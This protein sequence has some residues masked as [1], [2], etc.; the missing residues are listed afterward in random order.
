MSDSTGTQQTTGAAPR[1]D[2]YEF[3][4]DGWDDIEL[5]V[6]IL[7]RDLVAESRRGKG[8]N[9]YAE[10]FEIL[11][12]E[13]VL[14]RVYGSSPR[15]GEVH[16]AVTSTACDEVVPVVRSRWPEHRVSRVDSA[17]DFAADFRD[18][19]A[20]SVAYAESHGISYRLVTDSSGGATRYLGS[21]SSEVMVRVYKKS[22]QMRALHPDRA[23]EIPDGIVRVELQ[24]RPGKREV[25]ERVS[26]MT[27]EG[28]W[29]LSK[30]ARNF[31]AEVV[32][33]IDAASVPTHFARPSNYSRSL[34]FLGVQYGPL[35]RARAQEIGAAAT[36]AELRSTLGI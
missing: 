7:C 17:V 13:D 28:V 1:F 30:W 22:E 4:F 24:A 21:T 8:R 35:M 2:W 6:F 29:G 5:V 36:L 32:G 18:L 12:G 9:G 3:T 15:V 27:A 16:I 26:T 10:C 20:A 31:A 25:K 23:D 19:D 14:A 34:H 33:G 11:R